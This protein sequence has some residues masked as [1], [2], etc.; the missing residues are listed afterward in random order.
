[1][2]RLRKIA[3]FDTT[4]RDGEQVPGAKLNSIQKF[5]VAQ[6]LARLNVD[7]IE[8]GFP[9]SSPGDLDA[10][11]RIAYEV[12][13]PT[14][15]ALA[16]AL[17]PD[18]EA[19]GKAVKGGLKPR[20]HVFISTSDI[21]IAHQFKKTRNEVLQMAV[22]CIKMAKGIVDDVEYSPMDATRSE[23]DF[24]CEAVE[25][26]IDAG[27]TVVNIP[28]TVGYAIPS[29]FGSLIR[30]II[31]TVP[32]SRKAVI[33]VHCH[34]DL[35]LSVANSLAAVA[36][37]AG[38]VECTING[39]GERAG[40]ASLEEIVMAI[41]TRKDLFNAK[42]DI[43]T[44]EIARTSRLVSRT[45]GIPVQPNKAIVGANAFAHSSGIHTDGIIKERTTYEIIRPETVGITAHQF[46]LTARS[47]RNQLG[48]QLKMIGHKFTEEELDE[49]YDRFIQVADRKKEVT[50]E[51]LASIVGVRMG[52]VAETFHLQHVQAT[53]GNNLTPTGVVRIKIG[54]KV[55]EEAAVGD[56]PVDAL[57]KAI[58]RAT[59]VKG[60][61]LDYAIQAVGG[62]KDALGEVTVKVRAKRQVVMGQ[63]S[64]TDIV[65]TSARA[66][67]N[68][69]NKA[70]AKNGGRTKAGR[71][72]RKG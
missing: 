31:E 34:D 6:Q 62:G 56:G 32:N 39:V 22:D 54:D 55:I 66:Y 5:Q 44:K 18:V 52:Q 43:K 24:L 26:A 51:D 42:T 2:T 61:L 41:R 48:H 8:A 72:R 9:A 12:E 30:R 27:A 10:V 49:I 29:E 59:G 11:R 40:N 50:E 15:A 21:H 57:Y 14:I 23:F 3:I 7:I 20:I 36:N 65:E 13:G 53:S 64:G 47:G 37:G 16:R 4:L 33:S 1:M 68:A 25:R 38:Q 17:R 35:G 58:E 45:M 63:A 19:A 46:I 60:T 28:D 69:L 67:V 70:V 71:K